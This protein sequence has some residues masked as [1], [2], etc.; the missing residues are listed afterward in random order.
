MFDL[1]GKV[2]LLTGATGGIGKYNDWTLTV[3]R[4]ELGRQIIMR[5]L[6]EGVIEGRPGDSDPEAIEL[7]HK[8]A[9]KSRSRWPDWANPSAKVGLPQL[10]G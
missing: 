3:V 1:T 6:E 4:T 10:Q 9:A 7:M 2:V 5:M 8:L